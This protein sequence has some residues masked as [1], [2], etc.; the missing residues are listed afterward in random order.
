MYQFMAVMILKGLASAVLA[1][2]PLQ[3][4][5]ENG[6]LIQNI[7]YVIILASIILTS[8]LIPIVERTKSSKLCRFIFSG[9]SADDS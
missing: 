2:I 5:I 7:V 1:S 9:F 8:V 4:G 6:Y 3:Q